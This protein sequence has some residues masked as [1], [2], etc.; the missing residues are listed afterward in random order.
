MRRDMHTLF[1]VGAKA[2]RLP[3]WDATRV[4]AVY[5]DG[6]EAPALTDDWQPVM[7]ATGQQARIRRADCGAGCRCAGEI[8]VIAD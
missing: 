7:L 2:K 8:E 1:P 3:K 6:V 4:L 5:P